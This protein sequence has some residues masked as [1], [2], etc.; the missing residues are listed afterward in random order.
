M[1]SLIKFINKNGIK[2]ILKPHPREKN[3]KYNDI[4]DCDFE[5][6]ENNF[7]VEEII[8]NLNPICIIGYTSTALLTSRIFFDVNAISLL[9]M[10]LFKSDD[11]MQ[12]INEEFKNLTGRYINFVDKIEDIKEYLSN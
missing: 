11:E 2:P 9:D 1:Q 10:M 3:D 6:I 4:K 5:L 12:A 7:P 8:L